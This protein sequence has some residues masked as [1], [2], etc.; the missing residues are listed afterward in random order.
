MELLNKYIKETRTLSIGYA[1]NNG[2][3]THRI[4]DPLSI[5]AG[6][7]I[8]RDHGTGD[9]QAFRIHRIKGVAPL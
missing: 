7:L 2:S 8:A 1:D 3:A 9:V 6:S 4:V 5:S